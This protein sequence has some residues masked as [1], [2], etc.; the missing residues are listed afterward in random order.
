M[1]EIDD[2]V[3][4]KLCNVLC[5]KELEKGLMSQYIAEF[6]VIFWA[7]CLKFKCGSTRDIIR[8]IECLVALLDESDG[9]LT[10]NSFYEAGRGLE[11][12]PKFSV[13]DNHVSATFYPP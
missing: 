7:I 12:W 10:L 2:Q 1:I 3:M 4:S 6:P 8:H 5:G 9:K 13:L 11:G